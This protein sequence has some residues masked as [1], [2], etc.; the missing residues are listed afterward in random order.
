MKFPTLIFIFCLSLISSNLFDSVCFGERV[1]V[2]V[3][4]KDGKVAWSKIVDAVS[5]EVGGE[6]PLLSQVPAGELDINASSTRMVLYAI[7]KTLL[8]TFR[9]SI[10][11]KNETVVVRVDKTAVAAAIEQAGQQLRAGV[12]QADAVSG[13]TYGLSP[14]DKDADLKTADHIVLLI[15]G[16]GSSTE[17]MS[18]LAKAIEKD[19][20]KED[21]SNAVARFDY[22]SHNGVS[23]AAI[24]LEESLQTLTDDNPNC[25]ISLVTHSMGGVV[26]RVVVEKNDFTLS[27]VKRLVMVAPPNHG[28]QLAGLPSGNVSFDALLQKFDQTGLRQSLQTLVSIA[29]VAI[30]DLKPDS[31]CITDLNANTRNEN[32]AYSIILGNL[33]VLSK[34]ETRMLN[35]FAK[36]LTA[37]QLANGGNDLNAVLKSLPPEL[38]TGQGDGVVSLE[39]GK[40][41]GV[42]DTTVLRFQHSDLLNDTAKS[43]TKIINQILRRLQPSEKSSPSK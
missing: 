28:T 36:Q 32:I 20:Q 40:L 33:G 6:I 3:Q 21:S 12:D 25:E 18:S 31:K 9:I 27:Q 41:D 42:E 24:S 4:T 19:L 1:S 34:T 2:V 13:R 37:K 5:K 16:F 17:K 7:N 39:S 35:Q 23:A 38:I 14:F 15:H 8:P 26:A 30:E 10:N 43:Q 29:N 22:A 11:R